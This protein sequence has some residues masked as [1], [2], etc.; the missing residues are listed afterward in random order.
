MKIRE[1]KVIMWDNVKPL[2]KKALQKKEE[3]TGNFTL[4]DGFISCG[5]DEEFAKGILCREEIPLVGLINETGQ[6]L[7]FP[8]KRLIDIDDI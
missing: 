7:L 2:I 3:L 5:V 4:V 8:V 6:L 1:D